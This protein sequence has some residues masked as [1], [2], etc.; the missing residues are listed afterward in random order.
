MKKIISA[1]AMLTVICLLASCAGGVVNP[2][3]DP[4]GKIGGDT[5]TPNNDQSKK[6]EY[7][8]DEAEL[9]AYVE[10]HFVNNYL[11]YDYDL[12]DGTIVMEAEVSMDVIPN[13]PTSSN[14]VK[15]E[16]VSVSAADSA[17]S[18]D[19]SSTNVQVE[20][21]DE[22]DILKTD[23]KYIYIINSDRFTI[24]DITGDEPKEVSTLKLGDDQD[25]RYINEMYVKGN[26]AILIYNENIRIER[27][28]D[29]PEEAE[30]P[31]VIYPYPYG[32][33]NYENYTT[34]AVYDISD[35]S[36][37]VETRKLSFEG[38]MISSREMDG[39]LYLVSNKYL[40]RY[41]TMPV[42]E[43]VL[44]H[45]IDSAA[46]DCTPT[47]T[48]IA[49]CIWPEPESN[50]MTV[51]IIDYLSEEKP[52][53][54]SIMGSG[55]N[56]YMN[57][58]NLY[59]FGN[60]WDENGSY[61]DIAKYSITDGIEPIG[62]ASAPGYASTQ[63]AYD[64]YNGKFRI[65]TTSN[66]YNGV[67]HINMNNIYVYD[68]NMELCGSLTG[69]AP[70]ESIKSARFMGDTAYVVTFRQVD[71]LFVID[72]SENDPKVLGEL[73]I[74]GFSTY[75]HPVGEGLL[76]GIGS[77]TVDKV[78][79]DWVSTSVSGLKVSLFDV[80]DPTNP[81]EIDVA[82]Y[83]G[84]QNAYSVAKDNHNAFVYSSSTNTGYFPLTTYNEVWNATDTLAE[85]KITEDGLDVRVA[86]LGE[87]YNYN[88]E[89]RVCYSGEYLYLY[90][91]CAVTKLNRETLE[92]I[93][94]I[95][96]TTP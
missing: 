73:K 47:A 74:P 92:F 54:L 75:M 21:I 29:N 39:K 1:M 62:T 52:E 95:N 28:N 58:Q 89:S 2:D 42:I 13:A 3:I 65:A 15:S 63:F 59:I 31:E 61:T 56:I 34:V 36:A 48:E 22:G 71:P 32:Y 96:L 51:A 68:E 40:Y 82:N 30:I 5:A 17:V 53:T 4:N 7:F 25:Y 16:S 12:A 26:Y 43:E 20:G 91:D 76:L 6:I 14:E 49:K 46:G 10:E 24:V 35:R 57:A 94:E 81:T 72:M 23:G 37:P 60:S 70:D 84:G 44:P 87:Q 38:N 55:S 41:N 66:V 33:Y 77:E 8:T 67:K 69:L 79:G 80:S 93:C 88:S 78:Y 27:E 83:V 85:V 9:L 11:Y 64:E 45:I 50:I 19:V 18:D 86:E 90:R